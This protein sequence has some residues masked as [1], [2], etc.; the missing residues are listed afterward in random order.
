[1]IKARVDFTKSAGAVK[2]MHGVNNGPV[3]KPG[4]EIQDTNNM[5]AYTEAGFP[6]AR[7][8]DSAFHAAYGGAAASPV[9]G[10]QRKG[11]AT[12]FLFLLAVMAENLNI[13]I[14]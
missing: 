6:F 10:S 14:L 1:M 7:T 12:R 4:A 3:Y 13:C 11:T 9:R 2:P 5:K 8:H